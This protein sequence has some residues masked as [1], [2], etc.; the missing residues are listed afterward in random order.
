VKR[1]V[2]GIVK[3]TVVLKVSE[4]IL[5]MA[6]DVSDEELLEKYSLSW[7]QLRK[8]YEKLYYGGYMNKADL[9]ERYQLREGKSASHIPFAEMSDGDD[10]VYE[11]Q[12]CGY[13]SHLHFSSCPRCH[14]INLRRLARPFR[15]PFLAGYL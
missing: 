5:D 6:A 12:I 8:V 14:H 2:F 11:C 7:N 3:T 9:E 15:P 4:L 13:M 1:K 10:K